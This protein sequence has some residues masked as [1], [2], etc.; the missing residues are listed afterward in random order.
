[1]AT[2]VLVHGAYQGGWIWKPVAARLRAAGHEVYA[3]TLE[4]CAE[5]HDQVRVG[6]TVG[7]HAH[8]GG[9]RRPHV[10]RSRA[11]DA[12]VGARPVHASSRRRARGAHG[13]YELL[14]GYVEGGGH[15]L[16]P[17]A[18]PSGVA[19]APHGRATESLVHGDGHGALPDAESARRAGAPAHVAS[20]QRMRR[21]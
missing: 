3:P 14:G 2:Y 12:G 11:G 4:G 17:G 15:P 20:T 1:M 21:M 18:Q 5:R 10:R 13:A 7:T 6:I 9:C 8:E 19:S 16:P